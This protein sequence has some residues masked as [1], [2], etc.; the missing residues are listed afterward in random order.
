[1]GLENATVD[2]YP[3]NE[4]FWFRGPINADSRMASRRLGKER[5]KARHEG[6][7][8]TDIDQQ[9]IHE[10]YDRA[11]QVLELLTK[12]LS[13]SYSPFKKNHKLATNHNFF[14]FVY[15]LV[16]WRCNPST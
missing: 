16:H 2:L 15:I 1:M 3:R 6:R 9:I 13:V 10:P 12:A 7:S 11:I 14:S 8:I 5:T 4:A